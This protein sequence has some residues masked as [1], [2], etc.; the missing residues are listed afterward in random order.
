MDGERLV[1]LIRAHGTSMTADSSPGDTGPHHAG[2]I[3]SGEA[4]AVTA[5]P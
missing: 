1:D 2:A 5:N 3:S 4:I